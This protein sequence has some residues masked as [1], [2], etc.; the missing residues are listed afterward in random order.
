MSIAIGHYVYFKEPG[1]DW[2]TTPGFQNFFLGQTRLYLGFSYR[3]SPFAIVSEDV[4]SG[5]EKARA[6]MSTVKNAVSVGIISAAIKA[7][8]TIEVTT[9]ELTYAAGVF[10][11]GYAIKRQLWC[12]SGGG[13]RNG[14]MTM[15]LSGPG[16]SVGGRFPGRVLTQHLV[17]SVPS[18]G[19][20][21][22]G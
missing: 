18:T 16:D 15:E 7:R 5:G 2:L 17:G 21:Y 9:V 3:F 6:S 12:C 19:S 22:A 13:S 4:G 14:L 10:T 11:E 1:G 20:I 8:Y